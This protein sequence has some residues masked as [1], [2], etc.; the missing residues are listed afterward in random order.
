[1]GEPLCFVPGP[2]V[3]L[4][5]YVQNGGLEPVTIPVSRAVADYLRWHHSILK[6]ACQHGGEVTYLN[7]R[8]ST[9]YEDTV[10]AEATAG[11]SNAAEAVFVLV[12]PLLTNMFPVVTHWDNHSAAGRG[13]FRYGGTDGIGTLRMDE[14]G[15]QVVSEHIRL[16]NTDEDSPYVYNTADYELF[17]EDGSERTLKTPQY[18]HYIG[19]R[20][21]LYAVDDLVA[22]SLSDRMLKSFGYPVVFINESREEGALVVDAPVFQLIS[23]SLLV[24]EDRHSLASYLLPP[25]WDP[26]NSNRYPLLF[27]G[28]Y[29]ANENTFST[30]G[31]SFL[32]IIGKTLA[33]TGRG[34]VGILWNGGGYIGSRSLQGS[35]YGGIGAAIARARDRYDGDAERVVAVGGSRGGLTALLAGGNPYR[36]PYR[37]RYTLCYAPPLI[38]NGF[39]REHADGP[40]PLI[41]HVAEADTG[42]RDIWKH[43]WRHPETGCNAVETLLWTL[44]GEGD[45][46]RMK[47]AAGLESEFF[48]SGLKASGTKLLINHGTHDA[49]TLSRFS[50]AYAALARSYGIPLRHE[51]GYRFGH[52]NC[53]DLYEQAAQC[54]KALLQ[55]QELEFS[56]TIHYRRRSPAAGEWEQAER[57][58][59][60]RQPVFLEAP[61]F[62]P[63][64]SPVAWT[65]YGEQGM[66]YRLELDRLDQQ[67]WEQNKQVIRNKRI[68][69]ACGFLPEKGHPL[70]VCSWQDGISPSTERLSTGYYLYVLS[71]RL[72]GERSWTE[73]SPSRVPQ[74]GAEPQ[75]VLRVLEEQPNPASES[76][77]A[78]AAVQ[79]IGCG[80]SEA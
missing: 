11:N 21:S 20:Y 23:N 51:I 74:P 53:T 35:V 29:D 12:S 3:P 63:E 50:F 52:N 18:E 79:C 54:L 60:E 19:D 30:V 57:F 76:F 39:S 1:M 61:K 33:S 62:V 45:T 15:K 6:L 22:V 70:E 47:E 25:Y 8:W 32:E 16:Y 73:I 24:S 55:D 78:E 31:P 44:T 65:L 59:P 36:L 58:S 38:L 5:R 69:L 67:A 56:G 37:V 66:E 34:A 46:G 43:N 13:R 2:F 49:F 80:L 64:G 17:G 28:Y 75:S 71:Y 9:L 48:L 7:A 72:L 27:N 14:A 40:C 26:A 41:W 10:E 77:R 68:S 42:Y 4:S